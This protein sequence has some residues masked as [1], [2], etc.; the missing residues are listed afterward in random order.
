MLEREVSIEYSRIDDEF[1][2][3]RI[4]INGKDVTATFALYEFVN[5][6]EFLGIEAKF[7]KVNSQIGFIF[8][9]DVNKTVLENEIKRFSRQFDIRSE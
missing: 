6:M 4:I 9:N 2:M 1:I 3:V 8:R 7:K 5:E